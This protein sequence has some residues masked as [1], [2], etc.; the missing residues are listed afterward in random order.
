MTH[1]FFMQQTLV[2]AKKGWPYVAPNPLVGCVIVYDDKIISQ[3][4][5]QKYGQAHAEVN[6]IN[7]LPT[8]IQPKDCTLYVTLEPCSHFGKTPPCADLIIAKG[9]KTVVVA[10]KDPNPVVSGR[11]IKKIQ[12]AGIEVIIN[13]LEKEARELNKHFITFFEKKH[14]YFILKWAQT[15]DGFI[16]RLPLPINKNDNK[17]TGIQAQKVVH[18]LRS[19][20][21]AIM[22]GKNTVLNDNPELTTRLVNGKSPIRLFIDKNLE[23]PDTFNIY[24]AETKTIV[25]NGIKE[26]TEKNHQFIK[27]NF[28]E[29]IL[30]Q[31][32]EKLIALNI[33]SV[34]VEGGTFLLQD[35]IN[36]NLWDEVLI[37]E[38]PNL[39]FTNGVK[40]PVFKH[41]NSFEWIE[42]D[43]LFSQSNTTT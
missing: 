6:A 14:P 7:T 13:V 20:V 43:K 24:N 9:F 2:L 17:I 22:V 36:Q 5:H 3:G 26:S 4:Y 27:I 21:M 25:F 28:S 33:Q 34:L 11:G 41:I 31:V 29:N 38:N 35:F 32:S 37:F 16:S 39:I 19:E 15:A 10:C 30:T 1:K 40:A 23:V 12:E 8:N 42:N 18:Q